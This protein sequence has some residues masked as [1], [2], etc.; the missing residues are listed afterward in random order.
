MDRWVV[1]TRYVRPDGLRVVR[2][3]YT[4]SDGLGW[5]TLAK[6]KTQVRRIIK[7]NEQYGHNFSELLKNKRIEINAVKVVIVN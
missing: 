3:V 7:E 5:S 6:A 4:T 1:V 2:H